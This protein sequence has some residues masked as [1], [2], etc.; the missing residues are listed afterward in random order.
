MVEFVV[1]NL[2]NNILGERGSERNELDI[3]EVVKCGYLMIDFEFFKEKD[4]KG[5]FC[6][7]MVLIKDGN[8]VVFNV[9]DCCVVLSVGGFVEVLIFDY[10]FLRDDE[11]N[12]IESLVIIYIFI[13]IFNVCKLFFNKFMVDF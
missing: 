8:F 3:E 5:G 11:W 12:R 1:K 13:L 4:V 2:C 6:C 10:C 9:G 7:V